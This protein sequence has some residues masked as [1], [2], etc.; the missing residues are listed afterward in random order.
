MQT[1]FVFTYHSLLTCRDHANI[2]RMDTAV[3]LN[4]LIVEHSHNAQLV[5]VNLPGPPDKAGAT[6]EQNCIPELCK[7]R[8]R[9]YCAI[10]VAYAYILGSGVLLCSAC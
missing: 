2:R 1:K 6:E 3:R 10:L 9:G 4:E 7:R 5:M 8:E